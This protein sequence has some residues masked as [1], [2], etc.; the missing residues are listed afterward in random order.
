MNS[1]FFQ[2]LFYFLL[3]LRIGGIHVLH[4]DSKLFSNYL[5]LVPRFSQ[6]LGQAIPPIASGPWLS[7]IQRLGCSDSIASNYHLRSQ[8]PY[9][10]YTLKHMVIHTPSD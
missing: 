6:A 4:L 7:K 8:T 2:A 9:I 3:F 10:S 1:H 5:L